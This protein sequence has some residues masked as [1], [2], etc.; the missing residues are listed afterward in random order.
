MKKSILMFIMFCLSMQTIASTKEM[1]QYI[2]ALDKAITERGKYMLIK[3]NRID[4]L[5]NLAVQS[6]DNT[7]EQQYGNYAALINEYMNYS[8]DSALHYAKIAKSVALKADNY[9]LRADAEMNIA[10]I[11]NLTGLMTKDAYDIFSRLDRDALSGKYI[12]RYYILGLQIYYN[13]A[14]QAFDSKVN[15][16]YR[17]IAQA[18]RDSALYYSPDNEIIK[19]NKYIEDGNYEK[20]RN[21][22][23][24]GLSEHMTSPDAA[25]RFHVLAKICGL[26]NNAT[27][28]KQYLAQA[29]L[30]DMINGTREYMALQELA[31]ML[32]D[33]GD[34]ERAYRY[35]HRSISDAIA[36]NARSR[37][38]EMSKDIPII[39]TDYDRKQAETKF[40]L[41]TA[42]MA[43]GILSVLLL[44]VSIYV[45][46]RNRKL[47]AAKLLQENLN[48][49]LEAGNVEQSRLNEELR[50]L[51]GNLQRAN[52]EW[53]VLNGK[54]QQANRIK[55]E[56][57]TLFINMCSQYLS[58]ME[59][60]R[61]NLK[62]I[63]AQRNFDM[64]YNAIK[65]DFEINKEID[66]FYMQFDKAFLHLFPTFVDDFNKL[67]QP[68]CKIKLKSDERLNTELR[69]FALTR[70]GIHDSEK[71]AAFLRCSVSTIYN[72]RTKMKNRAID[73]D[74]FEEK[75]MNRY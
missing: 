10:Y 47:Q 46:K 49:Q 15:A 58:K 60:Y 40:K 9:N 44:A 70:L 8:L 33:E 13:L 45:H 3:E 61:N 72:Y 21:I 37:M 24:E 69:I 14:N 52:S 22:V 12:S 28:R 54:L 56:Y 42:C 65:S 1:E 35:I 5:K 16:K 2:S 75:F 64:L 51:N 36:C 17:T 26:Q 25:A 71:V 39:D 34:T 30:L 62:K 68:D 4:R 38:L 27:Q 31:R 67:L 32:Y 20:A 53:E 43:I 55:E 11:Y 63:A 48:M 57:I 29:A 41:Y 73:R 74:N 19:A 18:Y 50:R 6:R 66:E 59:S 7:P 23:S